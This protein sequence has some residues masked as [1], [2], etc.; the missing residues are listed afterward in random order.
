MQFLLFNWKIPF[1]E[2]LIDF[3]F[4]GEFM[5]GGFPADKTRAYLH[6]ARKLDPPPLYHHAM[7]AKLVER[8]TIIIYFIAFQTKI[9]L[10]D[11]N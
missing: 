4:H 5:N 1:L 7:Q 9:P 3:I 8:D 2:L 11:F 10:S 6:P